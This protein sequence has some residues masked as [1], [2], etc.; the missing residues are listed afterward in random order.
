MHS[1][2][3]YL[4]EH[5]VYLMLQTSNH[6]KHM[7][8][9]AGK[10]SKKS[11]NPLKIQHYLGGVDYPVGRAELL[12]KAHENG[13]PADVIGVLER[14]ADREYATPAEVTK[15]ASSVS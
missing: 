1:I 8:K 14:I 7:T 9:R 6:S 2:S 10:S 11:V 5:E 4:L 12:G 15:A 13:A 3:E